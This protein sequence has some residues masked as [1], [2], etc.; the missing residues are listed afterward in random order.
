M[1]CR[2]S[3]FSE[4]ATKMVAQG[5]MALFIPTNNGLPPSKAGPDLVDFT[6]KVDIEMA[7]ENNVALIRADVA[8]RTEQL[9]SY[10]SSGIV[11]PRGTSNRTTSSFRDHRG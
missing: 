4:T 6:R 2:D 11:A 5:A 7:T 8:G 10:D 9:I 1:I 3:L